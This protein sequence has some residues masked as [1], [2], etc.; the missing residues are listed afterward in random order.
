MKLSLAANY[1]MDLVP[2]LKGFPV[3]EVYGRL[4]VDFVG[5]GRPSYMGTALT[6]RELADYVSHLRAHG[7][8]FN[9]LLN[10]SCLGNQEWSR[11]WQRQLM[12]FLDEL[13]RMGVRTLTVST[14][15]LLELIRKRCPHFAVKVGIYAQVDTPRRA[16]FWEELGAD[17][18]NLESFS[19]N[20]NLDLLA[21]I[22]KAVRCDLQ[23]IPNH[24]CLVNC[25]M[26]P[27]HQNGCAHSSTSRGRLFIDYSFL[28]C[29]RTRLQDPSSFIKAQWI[30]PEDLGKYEEMGY[31]T[32]KL[33]ERGIPSEELLKRVIA[34]SERRYD[35]NLADLFLSYG[36]KTEP[37]K[38]RFWFLRH[39]LKPLQADPLKMRRFHDL[40]RHQG[41]LYAKDEQ[42]IEIQSSAIPADFLGGFRSRACARLAC[43]DCGYCD[44]IADRAVRIDPGYRAEALRHHADVDDAMLDGGLWGVQNRNWD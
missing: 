43:G 42:A 37:K 27:Y 41:M 12:G 36:F 33:L 15:F 44:G 19:I 34:Y 2:R 16:R 22:R 39:F 24:I 13:A 6:K 18:I 1:D 7:I 11:R 5:G 17:S 3:A 31:T 26:Q 14:P 21:A 28:R 4:P 23:L 8:A 10:A 30:R 20:R 38:P 40:A 29:C 25:P 35:G 32:F 9:Y